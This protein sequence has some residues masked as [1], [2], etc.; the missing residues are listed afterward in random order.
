[1]STDNKERF[2]MLDKKIVCTPSLLLHR[3]TITFLYF[4]SNLTILVIC[5]H[6][7]FTEECSI[8]TKGEIN[9]KERI[10]K[11]CDPEARI[12][13]GQKVCFSLCM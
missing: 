5:H 11:A 4:V 7:V 3:S 13:Y 8:Q 2:T 1:M 12:D 10:E 6:F 9:T